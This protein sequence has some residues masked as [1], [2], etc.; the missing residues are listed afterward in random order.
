[1]YLKIRRN[2]L[3]ELCIVPRVAYGHVRLVAEHTYE[4][5]MC[6]PQGHYRYPSLN[7]AWFVNLNLDVN[8][9]LATSEYDCG[10]S[11]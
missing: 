8:S 5:M 9:L 1:M 6:T 10:N 4:F 2:H 11:E 7:H 3:P